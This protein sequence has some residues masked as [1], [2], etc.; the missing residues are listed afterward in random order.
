MVG[1]RRQLVRPRW[2][3]ESV[4]LSVSVVE[5]SWSVDSSPTLTGLRRRRSREGRAGEGRARGKGKGRERKGRER[6][7]TRWPVQTT[8]Q[9]R[10]AGREGGREAGR[11]CR[12]RSKIE[13]SR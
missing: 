13:K 7:W 9:D 4:C 6:E 8:R 2:C 12:R 10:G 3:F 1:G 11:L 5:S